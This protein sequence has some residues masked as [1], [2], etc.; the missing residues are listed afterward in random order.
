MSRIAIPFKDSYGLDDQ[1]NYFYKELL[2]IYK[3]QGIYTSR[4][5]TI[6]DYKNLVN[7]INNIQALHFLYK[8]FDHPTELKMTRQ[9]SRLEHFAMSNYINVK[10]L[11]QWYWG[12]NP[13]TNQIFRA[14]KKLLLHGVIFIPIKSDNLINYKNTSL[15]KYTN[16]QNI[17]FI[18]GDNLYSH[19]TPLFRLDDRRYHNII[20]FKKDNISDIFAA[21]Y[22]F[23][24]QIADVIVSM[25]TLKDAADVDLTI[26]S[27]FIRE[28][29][30]NK[31]IIN[32]DFYIL[33]GDEYADEVINISNSDL[34]SNKNT[35]LFQR[36][37]A[38][39]IIFDR[40]SPN[41]WAYDPRDFQFLT[42]GEPLP[43]DYGDRLY[44]NAANI[45]MYDQWNSVQYI[46]MCS[47]WMIDLIR[48]RSPNISLASNYSRIQLLISR[49][50][51]S[52]YQELKVEILKI[53]DPIVRIDLFEKYLV[54][55]A[56]KY[57]TR[58]ELIRFFLHPH[59]T[60]ISNLLGT[61]TGDH[62]IKDNDLQYLFNLNIDK[63]GVLNVYYNF[64]N[65]EEL[66]LYPDIL[67]ALGIISLGFSNN[68]KI[69]AL[70]IN[71]SKI[72]DIRAQLAF[73][74]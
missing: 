36:L 35:S 58:T 44:F 7:N 5:N 55:V 1:L 74:P 54:L 31:K 65:I 21:L 68:G 25:G 69:I 72:N 22:N 47:T 56:A 48:D 38:Q 6:N 17:I 10:Y 34:Y 59:F 8:I 32:K 50:D 46:P 49:I 18:D 30:I 67:V 70:K 39:P 13:P 37:N 66:Y 45:T 61:R 24:P 15:N 11:K 2:N 53:Q 41:S 9:W 57:F 52:N 3:R 23:N 63:P 62:V 4:Q 42:Y 29:V 14:V 64:I 26:L 20:F 71:S 51:I 27:T 16:Y 43:K 12:S 73:N 19:I 40:N 28:N 60:Y 33:T